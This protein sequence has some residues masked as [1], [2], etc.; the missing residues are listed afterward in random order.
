MRAH[1]L[2]HGGQAE[3]LRR[4][5]CD[6]LTV[7]V[8]RQAQPGRRP[9]AAVAAGHRLLA[10]IDGDAGRLAMPDGVGDALL[11]AAVNREIDRFPI[12]GGKI[13]NGNENLRIGMAALE[14]SNQL[15][16]EL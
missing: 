7:I 14:P 5:E 9:L 12:R 3:A 8:H 13:A 2:G 1:A 16:E 10:E 6:S 11:N 4:G 15:F